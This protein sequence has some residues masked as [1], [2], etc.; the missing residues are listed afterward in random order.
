LEDINLNSTQQVSYE[1]AA[2]H[3]A[4]CGS[5]AADA[6]LRFAQCRGNNQKC[7]KSATWSYEAMY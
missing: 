2:L 4:F 5:G 1:K 3:D 6:E 7:E